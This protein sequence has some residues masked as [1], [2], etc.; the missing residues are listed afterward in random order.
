MFNPYLIKYTAFP[1]DRGTIEI[2]GLWKVRNGQIVSTNHLVIIDPRVGEKSRNKFA[3]WLPL[4]LAMFFVK[5]R[6]NVI[7][8]DVPITGNLN[9]PKFIL[10]D[11]IVDA[12]K[13]IFVKPL[14]TPYRFEVR[15]TETEIE[16]WL[17]LKWEMRRNYLN[18]R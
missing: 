2:K 12:L 4:N 14:T 8:Y 3:S 15:N 6:G 7:D 13:N 5:E 9:N 1:L 11:V 18:S 16:N 10:R 17:S